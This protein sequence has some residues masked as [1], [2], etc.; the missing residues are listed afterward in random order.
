MQ[1]DADERLTGSINES[2]GA[3]RSYRPLLTGLWNGSLG[4]HLRPS[5][6]SA[7]RIWV[8]LYHSP[9]LTRAADRGGDLPLGPGDG[10]EVLEDLPDPPS[11]SAVRAMLQLREENRHLRRDQDRSRFMFWAAARSLKAQ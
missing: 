7:D 2:S 4:I 6:S 9:I 8:P 5:A 3:R 10:A 1:T 11:Y